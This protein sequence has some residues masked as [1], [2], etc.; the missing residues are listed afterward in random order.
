MLALLLERV[1][2]RDTDMTFAAARKV[3]RKVHAVE[4]R[5]G[6]TALWQVG[7][8]T[9]EARELMKKLQMAKLPKVLV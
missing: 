8:V 6:Q 7:G 4:V 5:S 9:S 1:V 3:L 2:E